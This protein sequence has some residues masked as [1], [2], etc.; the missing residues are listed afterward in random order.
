MEKNP[1]GLWMMEAPDVAKTNA[2]Y[3]KIQNPY[4]SDVQ[5]TKIE[6]DWYGSIELHESMNDD[7]GIMRMR[8]QSLPLTFK[9]NE[10]LKLTK[11]G[12][13]LMLYDK[14]K[15]NGSIKII[16]YLSNGLKLEEIVEV[17][18]K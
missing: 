7:Y 2:V 14:K 6:S 3:G 16:F 10:T 5:I 11:G 12:K 13:H 9:M 8:K 4:P 1:D 17:R 18:K 15:N